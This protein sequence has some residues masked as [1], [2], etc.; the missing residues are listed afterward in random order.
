MSDISD[1]SASFSPSSQ[2]SQSI[3]AAVVVA[4]VES[5]G[6]NVNN[7]GGSQGTQTSNPPYQKDNIGQGGNVNSL[8]SALENAASKLANQALSRNDQQNQ[9]LNFPD[10][11]NDGGSNGTGGN[12]NN[13]NNGGTGGNYNN[14]NNGGTGGNYN[15]NYNALANNNNN[16]NGNDSSSLLSEIEDAASKLAQQALHEAAHEKNADDRSAFQN[17]SDPSDLADDLQNNAQ[18]EID[19]I[20]KIADEFKQIEQDIQ[21]LGQQFGQDSTKDDGNGVSS[22]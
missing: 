1:N 12:Y 4:V 3:A 6:N 16:G 10:D 5:E 17:D 19:K 7:N 8:L 20:K 22:A 2:G 9:A 21:K 15:D 18:N 13:N 11:N 14:N